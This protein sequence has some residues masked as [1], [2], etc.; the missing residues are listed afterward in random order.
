MLTLSLV[1]H[2]RYL[3]AAVALYVVVYAPFLLAYL[4][5]GRR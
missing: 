4:M 3:L 5:G 2:S 1:H